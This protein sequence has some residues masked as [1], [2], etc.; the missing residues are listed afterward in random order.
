MLGSVVNTLEQRGEWLNGGRGAATAMIDRRSANRR[1]PF[2]AA[3]HLEF[4]EP[5]MIRGSARMA[6]CGERWEEAPLQERRRLGVA[7][8]DM[9]P[10]MEVCKEAG[11]CDEG[12]V[13]GITVEEHPWNPCAHAYIR[14]GP[15][16]RHHAPVCSP[17]ILAGSPKKKQNAR[18]HICS[19]HSGGGGGEGGFH[20]KSTW[21]LIP[22]WRPLLS[23]T[24]FFI[25]QSPFPKF[26]SGAK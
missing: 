23:D 10:L 8:E 25:C 12:V 11:V 2:G 6:S 22:I 17:C 24:F 20:H 14:T 4:L 21:C 3:E 18:T 19:G 5:A 15:G 9:I 13:E 16:N 26:V 1:P 7:F